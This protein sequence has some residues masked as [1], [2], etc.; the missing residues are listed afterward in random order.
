MPRNAL[1][2]QPLKKTLP[3][4]SYERTTEFAATLAGEP[5]RFISKPGFPSWDR[6]TPAS[7]L[8]ADA[9]TMPPASRALLLGCGHGALGVVLARRAPQGSVWL[10]DTN[11]IA[12][13]M[14]E[15][16]LQANEI[17]N[18]R[19]CS[20]ISMLPAHG[21]AFD[22]AVMEVPGSRGLARRWLAE[23]YGA[24]RPGGQLYLAGPNNQGIQPAIEDARA[25]FGNVA[26]LGYK[27]RNRVARATKAPHVSA[28]PEWIEQ[29]GIQ[30]GTWHELDIDVRGHELHLY[31]LPGIFAYDRL[32][33]GTQLL[34]AHL[35]VPHDARVLDIGCGYGIIGLLA[36]RLGA[37]H[38]DMVDVNMLAVAAA[39]RNI[40]H[41]GATNARALPSDATSAV[42]QN[43][44]DLVVTN[45]PFHAGK[46]VDYDMAHAFIE[47]ARS[48]LTPRGR[49][50]LVA[51]KFIRYD[52]FARNRFR[53]VDHIAENG[54]YQVLVAT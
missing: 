32:D 41:H 7:G 2:S 25:L 54:R 34:L 23:A 53:H 45:P 10:A 47:Q 12:L 46:A 17:Q 38:V 39:Q 6:A 21:E 37:A 33:D 29:A 49:F 4:T 13:T 11:Y 40:V 14:A 48:V 30:P 36:A 42:D 52:A 51:N 28:A 31:S 19:V 16:T 9:V 5:V 50:V 24:L 44:Y 43:R 1:T 8:L 20:D 26:V 27:E 15:Q 22:V 35:E 3:Q 18:A